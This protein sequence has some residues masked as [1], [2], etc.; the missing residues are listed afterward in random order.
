MFKP[1]HDLLLNKEYF[2]HVELMGLFG[3]VIGQCK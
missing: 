3:P 1:I 2:E